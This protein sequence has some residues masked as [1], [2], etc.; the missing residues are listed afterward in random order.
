MKIGLNIKSHGLSIDA[1]VKCPSMGCAGQV[2]FIV[3]TGSPRS[4]LSS[5][6]GKRL[7]IETSGLNRS[8]VPIWG[9]GGSAIGWDLPEVILFFDTDQ[10]LEFF[11]KGDM[12][13]YKNP[14]RRKKGR[15]ITPPLGSLLG[16]DFL[17][18]TE[19]KLIVNMR[20]DEAYLEK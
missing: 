16:R 9:I 10:G 7:G 18:D 5:E 19:F 6:D 1:H 15:E 4:L 2:S 8:H 12:I 20:K 17:K 13:I 11:H 3:D 14:V